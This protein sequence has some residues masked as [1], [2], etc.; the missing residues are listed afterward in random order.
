ME[1]IS[2]SSKFL[3]SN[4][5]SP[6]KEYLS[7]GE[8]KTINASPHKGPLSDYSSPLK[9]PTSIASFFAPPQIIKSP[10]PSL[11]ASPQKIISSPSYRIIPMAHSKL[12][13]S[14]LKPRIEDSGSDLTLS[15][16]EDEEEIKILSSAKSLKSVDKN[17][18]RRSIP[19]AVPFNLDS[20]DEKK[21]KVSPE[22]ESGSDISVIISLPSTDSN[23]PPQNSVIRSQI[24]FSNSEYDSD[25]KDDE[26][27]N[28][29]EKDIP[30]TVRSEDDNNR[31]TGL[32]FNSNHINAEESAL[33]IQ[34]LSPER[35]SRMKVKILPESVKP[36]EP[37][38]KR[39]IQDIET[40]TGNNLDFI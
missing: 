20:D 28:D 35:K 7:L 2:E 9:G 32:V 25:A 16:G 26:A 24:N 13:V 4:G 38:L 11:N 36:V 37:P 14:P 34:P 17:C 27:V 10:V 21:E 8:K 15:E 23:E 5:D 18:H 6:C 31:T 1:N 22:E 19:R 3:A 33:K 12:T 39:G 29:N 30:F 40:N